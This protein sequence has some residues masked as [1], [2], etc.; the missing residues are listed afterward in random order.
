MDRRCAV[1]VGGTWGTYTPFS[2]KSYEKTVQKKIPEMTPDV[3][4]VPPE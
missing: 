2:G 1:V 4:H 3:P